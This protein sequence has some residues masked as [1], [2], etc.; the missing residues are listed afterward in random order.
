MSHNSAGGG[1]S[2]DALTVTSSST[3]LVYRSI[4][5]LTGCSTIGSG[6]TSVYTCAGGSAAYEKASY[7]T[8]ATSTTVTKSFTGAD[9]FDHMAVS[10]N[11]NGSSG[12]NS[13][14][15]AMTITNAGSVGIGRQARGKCCLWLEQFNPQAVASS[16]RMARFK[17]QR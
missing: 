4:A 10:I 17:P 15:T 11:Q 3:N 16:F 9:Y 2:S 12:S 8:G 6:E 13:L 5:N 7:K 1:G 14:T